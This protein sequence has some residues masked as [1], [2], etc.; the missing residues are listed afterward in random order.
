M[1]DNPISQFL[2]TQA[3][4]DYGESDLVKMRKVSFLVCDT[5]LCHVCWIEELS[6]LITQYR[7]P[8]LDDEI[9]ITVML[10]STQNGQK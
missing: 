6:R 9:P 8:P 7:R 1:D 5:Q 2:D 3:D 4:A 10:P